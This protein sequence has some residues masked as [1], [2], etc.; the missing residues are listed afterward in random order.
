VPRL[1]AWEI[2]RGPTLFE[3]I[4]RVTDMPLRAARALRRRIEGRGRW[5]DWRELGS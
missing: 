2:R 4:Y 1:V 5:P 3:A